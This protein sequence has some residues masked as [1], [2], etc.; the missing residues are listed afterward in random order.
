M[1]ITM[2]LSGKTEK[3]KM[4]FI[5]DLALP[6]YKEGRGGMGINFLHFMVSKRSGKILYE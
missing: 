4:P 6:F 2:I 1:C 5:V 3:N